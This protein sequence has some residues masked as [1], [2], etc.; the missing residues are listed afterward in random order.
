MQ[1]VDEQDVT[2][3]TDRDR[4]PWTRFGLVGFRF[5]FLY[6]GLF[7]LIFAQITYVYTGV[8]ALWLSERAVSWQMTALQPLVGWVART[9]F[10]VDAVLRPETG[11]GD[12]AAIWVLVF[13]LLV[14]AIVATAV[15]S[16]L[17]RR[18]RDYARLSA[19]FL[20]FL[21]LCLAGQMLFYGLAKV[22]PTQMPSPSPTAL[23]ERF[24]DLSPMAVLWL[25]VG[26]SHPYEIALGAVE[27]TAALLLFWP[28]T[29]TLGALVSLVGTGQI[30]LLNMTYDVPVKILS[31]HLLLISVVLLVPQ[32]R[33]L[34][35][36][37]VLQRRSDPVTQPAL[38]TSPRRNRIATMVQLG[39]GLWVFVGCL[40]PAVATWT[41]GGGPKPDDYGIWSVTE[42]TADGRP[43]PPLTTDEFRWQRLVFEQ[44]GAVTYQK[45]DGELVNLAAVADGTSLTLEPASG[46]DPVGVLTVDRPAPD[47]M[48]LTGRL[49]GRPVIISLA[50]E[51]LDGFTL[52]NRGFRWVQETAFFG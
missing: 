27:V 9:V 6:L 22:I 11:S 42:F 36:V 10:G 8:L 12:Q 50:Q 26:S 48:T 4:A 25:Q 32:L 34:V 21:R 45:M 5:A 37:L 46:G 1:T 24:G 13:C 19:F 14:V 20:V 44:P 15:W 7:C 39:L 31:F 30:F 18:R 17:D 41:S 49:E 43:L 52:R 23:L 33:R 38:F 29:A 35:D 40:V 51:P 3:V 28:R 16:V 2:S 47:R